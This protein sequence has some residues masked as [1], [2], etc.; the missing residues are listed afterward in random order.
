[1]QLFCGLFVHL[2]YKRLFISK[3]L[4]K[5]CALVMGV[6]TI[7]PDMVNRGVCTIFPDGGSR[8]EALYSTEWG[9]KF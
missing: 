1:M 8:C 3:Y 9:H 5:N 2:S 6:C 4:S 7:F